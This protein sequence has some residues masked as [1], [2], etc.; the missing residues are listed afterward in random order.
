MVILLIQFFFTFLNQTSLSFPTIK[1]G[2]IGKISDWGN[3]TKGSV[4]PC[5]TLGLEKILFV[6]CNSL[7]KDR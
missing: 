3:H 7:K 5:P 2:S 4:E 1:L 6:S